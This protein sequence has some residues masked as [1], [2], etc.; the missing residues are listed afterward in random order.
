MF[1]GLAGLVVSGC[2]K[3]YI[4]F[5]DQFVDNDY[6]HIILVD[7]ITPVLSTVFID[8]LITSQSGKMT[9]GRY[10]DPVFGEISSAAFFVLSSPAGV[11]DF[12]ISALFDSLEL[13]LAGDSTYYGDTSARQTFR[14][15]Q[16][17][18]MIVFPEGMTSLYNTT[19]FA[20]ETAPL[21]TVEILPEPSNKDTLRIRLIDSKGQELWELLQNKALEVSSATDFEHYFRGLK[22][23]TDHAH[24]NAAILGFS[25]S[26]VMRLHYHEANP[27]IAEKYIDFPVTSLNKQFNQVVYSRSGTPLDVM[28]PES[29][30]LASADL[31]NAAYIQPVTGVFMKVGFPNIREAILQRE[32]YLQ[33]MSA[34]LI[35]EPLGGSYSRNNM[36]PPQLAAY[37]TDRNNQ[38]GAT[39]G[40]LGSTS[41]TDTQYGDLQTDWL[42]GEQTYYKYDVTT[43]LQQQLA[44]SGDNTNA[45]LF[46]PPYP[47]L[48]TSFDRAVIGDAENDR[49]K[50]TL[51]IYYIAVQQRN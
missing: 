34:E 13:R 1:F 21:G 41:S 4:Q 26:V 14:V 28:I 50:V 9:I 46:L 24:A 44:L 6:T 31:S 38:L 47:A 48:N 32:D 10:A 25:D 23:S 12:H 45:L 36:L 51:K 7:T 42:N 20:V 3:S 16:L 5:G 18:E 29:K 2:K 8:S 22:I 11:P 39:L 15:H 35:L 49:G 27:G 43:Y 33:L 37:T 40:L 30:E 19:D 17:K